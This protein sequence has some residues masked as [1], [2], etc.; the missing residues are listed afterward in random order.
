MRSQKTGESRRRSGLSPESRSGTMQ[1]FISWSGSVSRGIAEA[2]YKWLPS[3]IQAV[4]PYFSPEIKPGV[5]WRDELS[6]TLEKTDF[7]IVCL[8]RENLVAPWLLFESGAIA[9][10]VGAS[11][12][13]PILFGVD[14]SDVKDPLSQFQCTKFE[15]PD[16]RRLM[17][18]MNQEIGEL[19]L[20]D[21]V[22][23]AAFDRWW[24]DL[25]TDVGNVMRRSPEQESKPSKDPR[26]IL[27]SILEEV[28][29]TSIIVQDLRAR[30]TPIQFGLSQAS[31]EGRYTPEM[32]E[33][34]IPN[35]IFAELLRAGY[36][37]RELHF[38]P[39]CS[40][41]TVDTERP[42]PPEIL[43]GLELKVMAAFGKRV[44][45]R[46]GEVRG[47][48]RDLPAGYRVSVRSGKVH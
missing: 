1:V 25:E 45:V 23:S 20:S 46:S 35:L 33:T 19:K 47:Q 43:T 40:T 3:V 31:A 48:D 22:L 2:L 7:G 6:G 28:R 18:A 26:E 29:S 5:R 9:K 13:C 38:P 4:K 11:R 36:S 32:L 30:T 15:K 37:A 44:S 41:I 24:P 27:E 16:I 21:D 17:S 39:G 10:K 34:I 12:L 14:P 8:T 42:V